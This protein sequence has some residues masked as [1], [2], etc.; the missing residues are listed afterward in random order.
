MPKKM[1]SPRIEKYIGRSRWAPRDAKRSARCKLAR[2]PQ[3]RDPS[4]FRLLFTHLPALSCH[5]TSSSTAQH[6][7]CERAS[8]SRRPRSHTI[9]CIPRHS[10][11]TDPVRSFQ[12][13]SSTAPRHT[14]HANSLQPNLLSSSHSIMAV[15][16]N[17]IQPDLYS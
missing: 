9:L 4:L 2:F 10:F 11:G 12:D 8:P 7:T 13:I 3:S 14:H 16:A 6:T 17:R 5:V 15:T 1:S